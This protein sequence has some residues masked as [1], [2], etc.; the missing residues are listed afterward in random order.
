[1]IK[2]LLVITTF[3]SVVL[4][5]GVAHGGAV[6]PSG[7]LVKT[8]APGI[9]LKD[10]AYILTGSENPTTTAKNGPKGS[11][12]LRVDS[13]GGTVY[14]KQDDGLSTNWGLLAGSTQPLT[15]KGDLFTFDTANQRLAVGVDGQ[16]LS[17]NSGT[18]T[19][20]QWINNATGTVTS[21]DLT[22]PAEF[23]VS[24]NPVTTSGTLAVAKANQAANIVYAGPTNGAAAAPTFRSLV[25]ADIPAL[26]Y[27]SSTLT[28]THLFVGN[29]GNV[30]TDVAASG[31]VTL[32]NTGAFTVA[33]VGGSTAANIG[34]VVGTGVVDI[35]NGGTGQ[36]TANAGFAALSPMTTLGD[37]I[38]ENAT[39]VP[40]RL[41][42]SISATK[43]FL[44][45]TGNG[46][47][48]AAP[49][50]GPIVAADVPN[51][52]FSKITTGTVP[53]GQGGTGQVTATAAFDALSPLTTKGD[54]LTNDGTNDVRFPVCANGQNM[55]ADSAQPSGWTC[56]TPSGGGGSFLG[57]TVQNIR[58]IYAN[59][60]TT[61]SDDV[62]IAV[63][64]GGAFTLFLEPSASRSN[65]TTVKPLKV[66]MVGTH[67]LYI[68]AQTGENIDGESV[69]TFTADRSALELN[70]DGGTI[71]HVF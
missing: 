24:G 29:A 11:I 70:A 50:W 63:T 32:A 35:A 48:S 10:E 25:A 5:A 54:M 12:Y 44:T 41:A 58:T 4:A 6:Y 55:Q 17:S 60:T 43:M 30:A 68:R 42:G 19:G 37:M 13:A 57:G 71:Y 2:A 45:Q 66:K 49:A 21:V 46:A 34:D 53:I 8:I 31:D 38:F 64:N 69:Q 59:H 61:Y 51:L 26:P 62:L 28:D 47:I 65:G 27:S 22:M 9:N 39:P 20:L 7:G 33:S 23:S 1:M 15:T 18:G 52:D 16:I 3:L 36:V 67:E 56:V 14:V 40:A